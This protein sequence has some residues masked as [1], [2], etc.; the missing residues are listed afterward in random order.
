[1]A[2]PSVRVVDTHPEA[3]AEILA[4]HVAAGEREAC[5]ALLGRV[6]P[7]RVVVEAFQ[8]ARNAHPA[9]THAFLL[10]PE[11]ALAAQRSAQGRGLC[12]VGT[13]HGHR[14]GAAFP[15]DADAA[16]LAAATL[17]PGAAGRP[18][19]VPHVFAISGCGSGRAPVLRAFL[20]DAG[21]FPREVTLRVVRSR[22]AR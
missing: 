3:L 19:E 10:H 5:G 12:V 21:R 1:M 17:A 20:Q 14:R 4:A 8:A 15:S 7:D 6:L 22:S 11:D 16:G 9:P 13:W 2:Q 18:A